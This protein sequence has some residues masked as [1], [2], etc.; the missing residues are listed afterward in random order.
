MPGESISFNQIPVDLLTPGQFVEFDNSKAIGGNVNLPQRILIIAAMLATGTAAANVPFQISSSAGGIAGLGR[1]SIG[2]A[3]VDALF[4]V[5]DTIE[6]WILP[7]ADNGAGQQASGT[8][9]VTGAPTAGGTVNLYIAGRRVQS[10]VS[11]GDSVTVIAANI[12]AAINADPDMPVTATSALGVVT[13]TCR[14]KGTLGND[15]DMR[16]NFYPLS[17][18]TP[19]GIAIAIT[20]MANGTGDPSIATALSNIGATQYNTFIMAFND[21]ANVTLMETELNARWGPL[22]QNDGHCHIG[23]RGTVGSLNTVLSTRNNP[24]ITT[25]TCEN[26]GEPGPVWEK[27]ALAGA[28]SAYYLAIDPA[29]PLQ[30]LALPGRLPASAEKRW[31]RS[32]RN[33]I[34]SYGGATTKVD[35][36]GNVIIERAVTNYKTN[37]AGIVDPSYRDIETMYTL[38]LMRYQVRARIAQ[39]FPRYKLADDG[40]QFA[41][42]QAVVTPK[43]L[44]AE[45]VALGLDWI[46]AALMEDI[47]QFKADLL[48]VRN[49]SDV[50]RA[51]VLLPPNL[52]NQFRVFAA[53]IQF[54]L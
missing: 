43:I 29:R 34:L 28:V 13:A 11:V 15:I 27:A 40:T 37:A 48:V 46:D 5:T 38:S 8:L 45:M 21:D 19:A 53:Q 3:M 12:A 9:T 47:D 18:S 42:G 2:A 16:L 39:K 51:D 33:N 41:P 31:Q 35:N 44:R 1:G 52:V 25:W 7:I 10:A 6:T 22:Y 20:A 4:R 17:E 26:G 23:K 36:G 30:T 32:E 24:H 54:R 14:H 49:G 50:N